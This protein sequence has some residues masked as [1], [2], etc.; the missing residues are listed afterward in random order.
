MTHTTITITGSRLNAT[1]RDFLVKSG[2]GIVGANFIKS[3]K[4][5]QLNIILG[6]LVSYAIPFTLKTNAPLYQQGP[7]NGCRK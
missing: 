1:Q 6:Q 2:F 5:S 4:S 3:V 7:C